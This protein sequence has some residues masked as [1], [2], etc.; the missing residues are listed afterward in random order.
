[1][2]GLVFIHGLTGGESTWGDFPVLLLKDVR[3]IDEVS[4]KFFVYP[5]NII[6]VPFLSKKSP[7]IQDISESLRAFLELECSGFDSVLLVAHSMGGLVARN[8][9]LEREKTKLKNPAIAGL[10][11]FATPN[12]GADIASIGKHVSIGNKHLKQLC[13]DSSFIESLN[14]DWE[15]L[16]IEEKYPVYYFGG[17]LDEVVAKDSARQYWG[18]NNWRLLHNKG[19]IDIVKPVDDRDVSY[20]ALSRVLDAHLFGNPVNEGSL[21]RKYSDELINQLAL[22]GRVIEKLTEDQYS[23]IKSLRGVNRAL[24][25]GCAGS[26]KTL[27]AAE[28]AIRLDK[29]GFQVLIVCSNPLLADQFS[30]LLKEFSV[31]VYCFYDW[32]YL[33]LSSDGVMPVSSDGWSQ[34]LEPTEEEII[35]AYEKITGKYDA[36]LIDEGQDFKSDWWVLLESALKNIEVGIFYIFADDNQSLLP[37]S[38]EYPEVET[39]YHLS[40]NCR[41]SGEIFKVVRRFHPNAPDVSQFLKDTGVYLVTRT[42]AQDLLQSFE[43]AVRD[44]VEKVGAGS[45][46][47]LTTELVNP[48]A[49]DLANMVIAKQPPWSWSDSVSIYLKKIHRLIVAYIQQCIQELEKKKEIKNKISDIGVARAYKIDE[50]K[51]HYEYVKSQLPPDLQNTTTPTNNDA[52]LVSK[53]IRDMTV[54][55]DLTNVGSNRN[56]TWASEADRLFL[57]KSEKKLIERSQFFKH[58]GRVINTS[59]L[60]LKAAKE[61]AVYVEMREK[62]NLDDL[63]IFFGFNDWVKMLPPM[64][65][66]SIIPYPQYKNDINGIPLYD[67]A[68]FKGLESDAAIV[69]VKSARD[70][71]DTNLYVAISRARFYLHLV[72]EASSHAKSGKL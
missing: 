36:I 64:D 54:C 11:M 57:I 33:L 45:L 6:R 32:M 38:G 27:I 50:L 68:S 5:T 60:E 9:L 29:A 67:V 30:F 62:I 8:Y 12:N 17:L 41:N 19:H 1:M 2:I 13:R 48:D 42:S 18:N 34:H 14:N 58:K 51:Q 40:K 7:P 28:K 44:A 47:V 37:R 26:G 55:F 16:N 35:A 20:L 3:Y 52:K 56:M 53:F 39:S 49:S 70:K 43:Q 61:K 22:V 24:I 23:V 15:T 25:Y 71:L 46:V 72:I 66:I 65:S 21:N 63:L 4:I 31:D 59:G 69:Y 10:V